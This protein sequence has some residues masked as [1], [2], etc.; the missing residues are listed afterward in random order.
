MITNVWTKVTCYKY[1]PQRL[2]STFFKFLFLHPVLCRFPSEN[3]TF[4]WILEQH[5]VMRLLL[6]YCGHESRKCGVHFNFTLHW[7]WQEFF[8]RYLKEREKKVERIISLVENGMSS[9]KPRHRGEKREWAVVKYVTRKQNIKF[10]LLRL[11]SSDHKMQKSDQKK[12][13]SLVQWKS[14]PSFTIV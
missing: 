3:C 4:F 11:S 9:K 10:K 12:I 1:V 6:S 14:G 13:D 8:F 2:K 7:N 5:W